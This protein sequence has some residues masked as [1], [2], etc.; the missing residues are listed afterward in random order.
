M[1]CLFTLQLHS[2]SKPEM[3]V[4]SWN[5][6]FFSEEE[7]LVCNEL[8]PYSTG[9]K[10]SSRTSN[11]DLLKVRTWKLWSISLFSESCC[12]ELNG[13]SLWKF[14]SPVVHVAC[15]WFSAYSERSGLSLVKTRSHQHNCG[16]AY[17]ASTLKSSTSMTV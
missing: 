2:G 12:C 1:V 10:R 5:A 15:L 4:E 16:W 7:R 17:F 11:I 13:N 3:I 9:M 14:A 6:W 8:F